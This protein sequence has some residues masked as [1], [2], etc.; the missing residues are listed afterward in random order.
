MVLTPIQKPDTVCCYLGWNM[1]K[2]YCSTS[3]V[4]ELLPFTDVEIE[5]FAINED[6]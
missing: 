5:K 4:L 2:Q 6:R 3:E 1:Y